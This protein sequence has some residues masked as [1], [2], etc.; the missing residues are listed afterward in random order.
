MIK[1]RFSILLLVLCSALALGQTPRKGMLTDVDLGRK[2][3][4][5]SLEW[6]GKYTDYPLVIP[7]DLIVNGVFGGGFFAKGSDT[8]TALRSVLQSSDPKLGFDFDGAKYVLRYLEPLVAGEAGED[9]RAALERLFA[10]ANRQDGK[11]RKLEWAVDEPVRAGHRAFQDKS[12]SDAV[13]L[14]LAAATPALTT[15]PDESGGVKVFARR[16]AL[17][18]ALAQTA[19][20]RG[21][22]RTVGY[23]YDGR[24][25]ATGDLDGLINVWD[26]SARRVL[27]STTG[28]L[29]ERP[30]T[31]DGGKFVVYWDRSVFTVDRATGR[32]ETVIRTPD[33]VFAAYYVGELDRLVVSD[34]RGRVLIG[35]AVGPNKPKG[36]LNF[37]RPAKCVLTRDGTQLLCFMPEGGTSEARSLLYRHDGFDYKLVDKE[38]MPVGDDLVFLD[39]S[40]DSKYFAYSTVRGNVALHTLADGAFVKLVS[41]RATRDGRPPEPGRPVPIAFSSKRPE[42]AV[43]PSNEVV[44]FLDPAKPDKV[45]ATYRRTGYAGYSWPVN[46]LAYAPEDREVVVG[47]GAF[48]V[49]TDKLTI[50][51]GR[52]KTRVTSLR[53]DVGQIRR[54]EFTQGGLK[55][56]TVSEQ[57]FRVWDPSL[58]T[59]PSFQSGR[60]IELPPCL[61]YEP[62][63]NLPLIRY[64]LGTGAPGGLTLWSQDGSRRQTYPEVSTT[65]LARVVWSG[66]AGRFLVQR[67]DGKIEVWMPGGVVPESYY[68]ESVTPIRFLRA[69]SS[70]R[71]FAVSVGGFKDGKRFGIVRLVDGIA[72]KVLG[73]QQAD[74]E[75]RDDSVAFA[76][77]REVVAFE[78]KGTVT[79]YALE[80]GALRELGKVPGYSPAFN[81][82]GSR[83]AVEY[84]GKVRV[85]DLRSN[86]SVELPTRDLRS[87]AF[88]ADGKRVVAFSPDR[89]T[90]YLHS[91]D[92]A[93]GLK[94]LHAYPHRTSVLD[95]AIHPSAD[96]IATVGADGYLRLWDATEA[97]RDGSPAKSSARFRSVAGRSPLKPG[98]L[99]CEIQTF[100]DYGY[101]AKTRDN[102]YLASKDAA[103]SLRFEAGGELFPFDQFDLRLNRPDLVLGDIGIASADRIRVLNGAYLK[104]LEFLGVP[105]SALTADFRV[106]DRPVFQPA[107]PST[108]NAPVLKTT[109]RLSDARYP[110]ESLHVF[111]NN[112]PLY[113][114]RGKPLK[115]DHGETRTVPDK[116]VTIPLSVG[117]NEIRVSVRNANLGMSLEATASVRYSPTTPPKPKLFALLVGVKD[118]DAASGYRP[119]RAS[120]S[121][122]ESLEKALLALKSAPV[123]A[124]PPPP[125]AKAPK[126]PVRGRRATP[127]PTP[128]PKAAPK[129]TYE[130]V[131]ILALKGPKATR[132]AIL[133]ARRFLEQAGP[134]DVVILF[135]AGHGQLE[136]RSLQYYFVPA[137]GRKSDLEGT[138]V[139]YEAIEGLVDGVASRRKLILLDSCQSGLIDRY[140]PP[141]ASGRGGGTL[142]LPASDLD[143]TV[144]TGISEELSVMLE[145]FTDLER[146]TG[147]SVI[148]AATGGKEAQEREHGFFTQAILQALGPK[149]AQAD[150]NKDGV[151]NVSE[152][153]NY[154]IREVERLSGGTQRP[155][156]RRENDLVNFPIG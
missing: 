6:L 1:L 153:R 87:P 52:T 112:V 21:E 125:A 42:L 69:S 123:S 46:A 29:A 55:M 19:D 66:D 50:L 5:E 53:G 27:R 77:L 100:G 140:V 40:A 76:M 108:S 136:D 131:R 132:T 24:F 25:L 38:P 26:T 70:G 147:S 81:A 13:E 45:V 43:S 90:V 92:L 104:R 80:G 73:E 86:G 142:S 68:Q 75:F 137:D 156:V 16:D 134:D 32:T 57:G 103:K 96:M 54:V 34:R 37:P 79:V 44:E 33:P 62:P 124:T 129:R 94:L 116:E 11:G 109:V 105:L 22:I 88:S 111:V 59:P 4:R 85:Y 91:F 114:T 152:L 64:L 146:G 20:H 35:Q 115:P 121:D 14:V 148:A 60:M 120:L 56:I 133:Q 17:M 12:L 49:S 117:T 113:G 139:S 72:A 145:S 127:A 122:V 9:V 101:L 30:W 118:Y 135:F 144:G 89:R 3:L 155:M 71:Y 47:L 18:P 51:D 143:P 48:E 36:A 7:K 61:A 102:H 128:A 99:V 98:S 151:I 82:D 119:L 106:P 154:V 63:K 65:N 130:D 84:E 8:Q 74:A 39:V 15:E 67:F 126:K 110:L 93:I 107:L 41:K 28:F 83:L 23:S 2:P 95:V 58:A 149:R 138:A 31:P 150:T 97:A 78:S 141:P 10:D